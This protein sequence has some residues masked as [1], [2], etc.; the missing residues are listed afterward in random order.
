M[1]K[2]LQG[3]GPEYQTSGVMKLRE[4][5]E[6]DCQRYWRF[7][8]FVASIADD[9]VPPCFFFPL[10]AERPSGFKLDVALRLASM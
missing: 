6:V 7:M 8:C 10:G 2:T 5:A 1:R 4:G 9:S 3:V